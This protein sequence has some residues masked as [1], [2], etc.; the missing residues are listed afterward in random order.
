VL[1]E[2]EARGVIGPTLAAVYNPILERLEENG[3]RVV[4]KV[5]GETSSMAGK[6]T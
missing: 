3:V 2:I 6:L 5:L 1:G 4:E